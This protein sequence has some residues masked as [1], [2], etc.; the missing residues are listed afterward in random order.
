VLFYPLDPG[1]RSGMNFFQDPDPEGMFLGEIFFDYLKILVLLLFFLIR[2]APETIWSK[3]IG[4][5]YFS[6]HFLWPVGSGMKTFGIR[7][8]KFRAPDPG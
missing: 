1:S 3:K 8:E 6:S 5:I 2:L 4:L 7:N